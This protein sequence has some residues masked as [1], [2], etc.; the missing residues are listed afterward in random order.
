M[1]ERAEEAISLV[2]RTRASISRAETEFLGSAGDAVDQTGTLAGGARHDGGLGRHRAGIAGERVGGRLHRLGRSGEIGDRAMRLGLEGMG[3]RRQ[4]FR[5]DPVTI[6]AHLRL[7]VQVA[8][9]DQSGLERR[10]GGCHLA[11]LVA[12]MRERDDKAEVVG[13]ERRH[14]ILETVQGAPHLGDDDPDRREQ[15]QHERHRR[16]D[17]EGDP[18]LPPV[19]GV[20]G[21]SGIQA[22]QHLPSKGA[23][24]GHHALPILHG[25]LVGRL[26]QGRL[27]RHRQP[28]LGR[29][30]LVGD[31]FLHEEIEAP[32]PILGKLIFHRCEEGSAHLLHRRKGVVECRQACPCLRGVFRGVEGRGLHH[33]VLDRL[34]QG[35]GLQPGIPDP[36]RRGG[37]LLLPVRLPD[38]EGRDADRHE[39]QQSDHCRELEAE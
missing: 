37:A 18:R 2:C 10:D 1:S 4:G 36:V 6:T 31:E 11:D 25:R 34:P 20:P 16:H 23:D 33:R 35:T 39:G 26:D 19:D 32:A 17:H 28:Q 12:T 7:R 13:G 14:A 30:G 9:L 15:P 5:P 22:A 29:V 24:L 3:R 8:L 21:A 27:G 38:G